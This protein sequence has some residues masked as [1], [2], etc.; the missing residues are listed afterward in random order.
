MKLNKK[1]QKPHVTY[2]TQGLRIS[3]LC[4]SFAL[5]VLLC[6]QGAARGSG[7][8]A[9]GGS[10]KSTGKRG[11]FNEGELIIALKPG[12]DLD[13]FNARH[14]TT[15][16]EV[17]P[18]T[19]QY[20]VSLPRGIKVQDKLNEITSDGEA[21]FALPNARFQSAEVR[22][23]SQPYLD[24]VSQ[25]YL[26]SA[27]PINFYGQPSVSRLHL[28]EAQLLSRGNGVR[29]AVIDTGLDFN[30]PLFAG[31][32]AY[33]YLDFV[34]NDGSPDDVLG[35]VGSGHGTFV[36]GLI[37]LTAPGATV[38]P[39][40]AFGPDG[41]GTSFNIAKA[42]RF[43]A[44]NGAQIINMSFGMLERDRLIDEA[45]NYASNKVYMIAAA[46]NDNQNL[47]HYPADRNGKT[48][49]VTSTDSRDRKAT[50]ANYHRDVEVSAPGVDLYSAYPG[51]RWATWSGTSFST[52]LVAG[53]AALVLAVNPGLNQSALTRVLTFGGTNVDAGRGAD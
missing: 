2:I 44:D 12:V 26:D 17:Q 53:E 19:H 6:L 31:R 34:D 29:V 40:R 8:N 14:G 16:K 23:V 51:G 28:A 30:H 43:A 36:A 42:I 1:T 39:L 13:A 24:Q 9:D 46:G 4:L 47:L 21:D 35:G 37:S 20:L 25:P 22:Q 38:M 10:S 7:G 41:S 18:G 50:W 48:L 45:L 32:I 52:A 49:S 27:S 3:L 11:S 33:P 5:L 15:V